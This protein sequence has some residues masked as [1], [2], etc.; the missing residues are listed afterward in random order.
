M[1]SCIQRSESR[2][3][4]SL[5]AVARQT[6]MRRQSITKGASYSSTGMVPPIS[7]SRRRTCP[8]PRSPMPCRNGCVAIEPSSTITNGNHCRSSRAPQTQQ[9][10]PETPGDEGQWSVLRTPVHLSPWI[11]GTPAGDGDVFVIGRDAVWCWASPV[12]TLRTPNVKGRGWSMSRCP[13]ASPSGCCDRLALRRSGTPDHEWRQLHPRP[14]RQPSPR[15][16]N[17]WS[18]SGPGQRREDGARR[19]S[20]RGRRAPWELRCGPLPAWSKEISVEQT[21]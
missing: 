6:C 3:A 2:G 16:G 4:S 18:E 21:F 12:L 11:T 14:R 7:T 1:R 5:L 10:S 20:G 17:G 15:P 9:S 19:I 8:W 13:A